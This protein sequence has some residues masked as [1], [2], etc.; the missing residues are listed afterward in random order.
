MSALPYRLV[1]NCAWI[2]HNLAYH[3][4]ISVDDKP[5]A[6]LVI[7]SCLSTNEPIPLYTIDILNAIFYLSSDDQMTNLV[8][9]E[10]LLAKLF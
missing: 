7:E 3:H 9:K 1:A 2:T 5:A 6:S 4:L 10:T 8:M